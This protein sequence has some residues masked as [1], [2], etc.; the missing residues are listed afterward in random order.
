MV[1]EMTFDIGKIGA[2]GPHGPGRVGR[3]RRSD[4]ASR[5]EEVSETKAAAEAREIQA[6]TEAVQ[7]AP[8]VR[9]EKI[10]ELRAKIERGDFKV[11]PE[12]VAERI[13]GGGP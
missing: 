4:K 11:D 13:I 10:A 5:P 7:S 6:A 8:D 3:A 12:V 9:L 2:T 1:L